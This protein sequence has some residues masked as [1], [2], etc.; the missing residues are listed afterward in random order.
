MKPLTLILNLLSIISKILGLAFCNFQSGM[1][2]KWGLLQTT[3]YII[4]FFCCM[5][6][7]ISEMPEVKSLPIKLTCR[8][9]FM[10]KI[11]TL[12]R[13]Y[14]LLG[15]AID[16][17]LI[18]RNQKIISNLLK[19]IS[20]IDQDLIELNPEKSLKTDSKQIQKKII[21]SS[22]IFIFV[23]GYFKQSNGFDFV[24]S[25]LI[26]DGYTNMISTYINIFFIAILITLQNR[27]SHVNNFFVEMATL[28]QVSHNTEGLSF[29]YKFRKFIKIHKGLVDVGKEVNKIF[30]PHLLFWIILCF[31]TLISN[32]YV[33]I[34]FVFIQNLI[35]DWDFL[36]VYF[37]LIKLTFAYFSELVYITQKTTDVCSEV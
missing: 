15:I 24:L 11:L 5:F 29:R 12:R 28:S 19:K 30:S 2:S 35:P 9:K 25:N 14:K 1:F 7:F 22:I 17:I 10:F 21:L 37:N 27:I 6:L 32:S 18:S 36:I 13:I 31:V 3:I 34:L 33:T 8:M 4:I 23:F 20:E 16:I 26:L